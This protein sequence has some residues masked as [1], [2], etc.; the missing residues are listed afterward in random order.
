MDCDKCDHSCVKST[1]M[2]KHKLDKHTMMC[3]AKQCKKCEKSVKENVELENHI[4]IQHDTEKCDCNKCGKTFVLKWRLR[5]L[6][7]VH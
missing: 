4:R 2:K 3:Q 7:S 5:K 6:M 1:D